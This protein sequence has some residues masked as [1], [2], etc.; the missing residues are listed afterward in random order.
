EAPPI[1]I[2]EGEDPLETADIPELADSSLDPRGEGLGHVSTFRQHMRASFTEE[3]SDYTS[4][5]DYDAEVNTGDQALHAI[6]SAEGTAAMELP[7]NTVEVIWIGTEMWVKIGKQPWVSVPEG[8]EALPFAK[9]ALAIGDLLP[10]VQ[11]F[12]KVD[13][14]T[15]NG[16][17]CAYY[18]YDAE[19]VPTKYGYVNG[20]GDIC[21]ALDG[22]YVVH[23]TL[24]GNGTFTEEDFFQGSGAIQ[25]VYDV[26]G[27]GDPIEINPPRGR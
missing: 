2:P 7:S 22:G 27:V 6:V 24:D 26:D 8:V 19:N 18:T 23:Y 21:V 3:G 17:P 9:Q 25:L 13:D 15:M 1:D 12:D 20:Q 14:R 10:Y 4:I 5:F 16:I 11:H